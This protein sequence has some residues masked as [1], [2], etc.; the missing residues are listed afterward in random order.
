MKFDNKF[1]KKM[2]ELGAAEDRACSELERNNAIKEAKE[3]YNKHLKKWEE[4]LNPDNKMTVIINIQV[5]L[6]VIGE[7]NKY[8]FKDLFKMSYNAL[9]ELQNNLIIKYNKAL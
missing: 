3:L 9:H 7:E 4:E 1:I 5:M 2:M 6:Q 8:T